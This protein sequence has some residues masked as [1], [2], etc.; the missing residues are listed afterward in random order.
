MTK[1]QTALPFLAGNNLT[2]SPGRREPKQ[3][4]GEAVLELQDVFKIYREREI[5]TVALRG[6]SLKIEAGEFVTIVGRSGSGKST[7]MG[8]AAGLT[9]PSAGKVLLGGRD[10]TRLSEEE[11]ASLRQ[12]YLGIVF[13]NNNLIPFLTARENVE[14][15]IKVEK[16]KS[17]NRKAQAIGLLE[18]VG[19]GNRLNHR[20]GQ[21]SGGEQ[22]RV[23]I[24]LAL[25]NKPALLLA[26]ELTGELDSFTAASIIQ[27]LR[28][29]NREQGM[30][31]VLVTHNL[32]LAVQAGR[33]LRMA[34]G[35]ITPFDPAAEQ[36]E[37]EAERQLTGNLNGP[38]HQPVILKAVA[39]DKTFKGGIL[40][41]R[42][43][44]FEV[45]RGESVAIMGPSGSGKST[46]LNLLGGLD[47]PTR[48]EINLNGQPLPRLDNNSLALLRRREIG[49]IFQAHNL[50]ATLS[51]AENVALP[52]I[53]DNVAFQERQERALELLAQLGIADLAGKLPDQMSG[54]QR[55]RV[56][57]ARSLA[58]RPQLLL[59]DEPTGSLDSDTASQVAGLLTEMAHTQNLALV[60]VTHDTQ[61]AARCDRVIHLIDGQLRTPSSPSSESTGPQVEQENS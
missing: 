12:R 30:V 42:N 14:L 20:P 46:L 32:E 11:R 48:G 18:R 60:M 59:A 24:A 10:I 39:L 37:I 7:L 38:T 53:L 29:L 49:F 15:A 2:T 26:D 56:A 52:L 47:R 19:L 33:G 58:H 4:N 5:E 1:P 31:I 51:A 21:L 54:G 22:Q 41:L 50:I 25:A 61:V 16:E 34:D 36:A 55:Q 35:L 40:A 27:L 8:I 3:K 57:I 13:Q 9:S 43:I 23:A 44:S 28:E 17:I 6:A 45:H